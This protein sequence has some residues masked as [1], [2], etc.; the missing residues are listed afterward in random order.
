VDMHSF[1]FSGKE[2]ETVAMFTKYCRAH[3]AIFA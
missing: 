2:K 3:G 1:L